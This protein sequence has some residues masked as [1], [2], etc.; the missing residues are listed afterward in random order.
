MQQKILQQQRQSLVMTPQLQQSIK[1][2]QM[3]AAELAG[4]IDEQMEQNPLLALESDISSAAPQGEDSVAS[5]EPAASQSESETESG[6]EAEAYEQAGGDDAGYWNLTPAERN[7]FGESGNILEQTVAAEAPSLGEHLTSQLNMEIEDP[8]ERIIGRYLIDVLDENGYLREQLGSVSSILHCD[9]AD[10]E[11][12]LL[13]L[14]E[15]DPP[16]VF[17]RDLAEC[18]AIQ[19]RDKNRLDPAME[20]FIQ[21]LDLLG[22]GDMAKLAKICGLSLEEIQE[23]AAEVRALNPKPARNFASEVTQPIRPDVVVRPDGQ[24][25][26]HVELQSDSLPRVLVNE[27]YYAHVEG[28]AQTPEVKRYIGEH[29][30]HANWLIKALDQRA[31]T[32]LKT[33]SEI[34]KQQDL[35]LK[36]G[37]RYLKPLTLKIV[38]DAIGMHE[39]TVS[40]V[41][42]G[43][44]MQ[45]PRG[46]LELKYFFTSGVACDTG[47][48]S[49]SSEAVKEQ[50]KNLIEQE[51]PDA[52]LSDDDIADVLKSRGIDIAR[53]TVAKYREAFGI[54]SSTERRRQYKQRG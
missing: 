3:T 31:N 49:L 51:Q 48:G 47:L 16:G 12:V 5:A 8:A 1:L 34:V 37:L 11:R 4:F 36:Y 18:L 32:I 28:R 15:F 6:Y 21:N 7:N 13:K 53:R 44:Y 22:R 17:A 39:S 46:L 25:G 10:V 38:A 20:K 29:L 40:R 42:N 9:V 54:G 2:L 45:T 26:W 27:K 41:T 30:Q 35:F 33:A 50:I 43:K 14:Q 52:V 23:M 24:N 19:L